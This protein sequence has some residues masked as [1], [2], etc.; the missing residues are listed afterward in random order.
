[1]CKFS[2]CGLKLLI[3]LLLFVIMGGSFATLQGRNVF[4]GELPSPLILP[5]GRKIENIKDW[6]EY[7]RKEWVE[8]F[9]KEMYGRLPK[10][11]WEVDYKILEID[12]LALDGNAIRKQIQA[13]YTIGTHSKTVDYLIYIPKKGLKATFVYMNFRGNF[14][15]SFDK[16]IKAFKWYEGTE[17][18]RSEHGSA[19]SYRGL[20]AYRLPIDYLIDN[21]YAIVTA[22]Y[23]QFYLDAYPDRTV[24]YNGSF[25][26]M[27][28]DLNESTIPF[29][30]RGQAIATW[31]WG[32]M[33]MM[34]YIE[35]DDD[36]FTK[37]S[38]VIG[39]SRLGKTALW[40]GVLDQRFNIVISSCSGSLGSAITRDKTGEDLE[41]TVTYRPHWFARNLHKYIGNYYNLPFDQHILLSLIAPRPLYINSASEDL[42]AAPAFEYKSVKNVKE[43]Y[44]GIY[45]Y[46]VFFPDSI[47]ESNHPLFFDRVGYHVRAGKHEILF[48]DWKN[49]VK[50]VNRFF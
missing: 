39:H 42:G 9:E 13:I 10:V 19:N 3:V 35:A 5:S 49:Y 46:H 4:S 20:R 24:G 25:C 12:T 36:F 33:R 7:G 32:Y 43:I 14:T 40:A 31:A 44:N 8:L 47:V 22:C 41:R 26:E 23:N 16:E 50:F 15:L 21:G 17:W 28:F 34:D 37:N 38:I 30:E 27:L 18:Q 1:M 11:A 45:G 29:D 48:Y 6:E 2:Y